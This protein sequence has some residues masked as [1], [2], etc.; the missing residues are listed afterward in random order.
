MRGAAGGVDAAVLIVGGGEDVQVV[1]VVDGAVDEAFEA[2]EG[3][4]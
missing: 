4:M 2:F 3:G 1:E